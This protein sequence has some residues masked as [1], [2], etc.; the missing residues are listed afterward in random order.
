MSDFYYIHKKRQ[1]LCPRLRKLR[2]NVLMQLHGKYVLAM[3]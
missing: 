3:K 2:Y 1:I